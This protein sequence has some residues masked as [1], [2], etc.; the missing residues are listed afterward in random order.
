MPDAPDRP[1]RPDPEV[2]S[3]QDAINENT[4]VLI[5]R[6]HAAVIGE[7]A[8]LKAHIRLLCWAIGAA[9]GTVTIVAIYVHIRWVL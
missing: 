3:D 7:I 2:R 9:A 1:S 8:K 5:G 4:A 6:L